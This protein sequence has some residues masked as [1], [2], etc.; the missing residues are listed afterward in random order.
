[1]SRRESLAAAIL[2]SLNDD[3]GLPL[4]EVEIALTGADVVLAGTVA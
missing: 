1:M 2:D 4:A 3:P